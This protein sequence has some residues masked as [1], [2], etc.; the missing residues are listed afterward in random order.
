MTAMVT[1]REVT[2]PDTE[3]V[4]SEGKANDGHPLRWVKGC[5]QNRA[6]TVLG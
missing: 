3:Q 1:H 4:L 6:G 5:R 2:G